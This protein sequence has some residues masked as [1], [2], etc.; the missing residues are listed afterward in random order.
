MKSQRGEATQER[1]TIHSDAFCHH[2][3][4]TARLPVNLG[5]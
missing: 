5:E 3:A 1:Y 2:V 4:L